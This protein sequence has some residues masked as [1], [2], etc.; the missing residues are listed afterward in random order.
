[1]IYIGGELIV[2]FGD[3]D[4]AGFQV[5]GRNAPTQIRTQVSTL[6][7]M[8]VC[9]HVLWHVLFFLDYIAFCSFP[10]SFSIACMS[11]STCQLSTSCLHVCCRCTSTNCLGTHTDTPQTYHQ[12]VLT[13]KLSCRCVPYAIIIGLRFHR[14]YW[15]TGPSQPDCLRDRPQTS[16]AFARPSLK[17]RGILA[18]TTM[19]ARSP[20]WLDGVMDQETGPSGRRA[21]RS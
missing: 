1:M 9:M 19:T 5:L 12:S 14:T 3:G 13:T 6:Y 4:N 2:S 8:Y 15:G 16:K 21:D 11:T 10:H 20:R 17:R 7:P 18:P